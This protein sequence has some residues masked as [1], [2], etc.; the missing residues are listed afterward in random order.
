LRDLV[1]TSALRR[2]LFVRPE[3]TWRRSRKSPP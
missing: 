3:G 2:S 1:G